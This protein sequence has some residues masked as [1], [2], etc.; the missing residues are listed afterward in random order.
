[1]ATTATSYDPNQ[2]AALLTAR[3]LPPVHQWNPEFCGDID[4]RI[5][6][7]GIWFYMGSPIGRK[8]LVELFS[9]VLR[10]DADNEFYLVTPVEKLRI[11]V[12]DAPFVAVQVDCINPGE[13]QELFFRTNVGDAVKADGEHP[14][15]VVTDPETLEPSP[16]LLV[17]DRLEALIARPVFYEL[18]ERSVER[19]RSGI[20]ELGVDSCGEFF[21]LGKL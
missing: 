6:R 1:M 14:I 11:K 13:N 15:R 21:S 19:T 3:K 9:T 18:V 16:Y 7:D 8:K 5:A 20:T 2:L 12:D 17:R 4:M 10:R